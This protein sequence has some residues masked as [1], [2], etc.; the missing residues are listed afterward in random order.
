[1]ASLKRVAIEPGLRSRPEAVGE[2]EDAAA[3][4][5]LAGVGEV[6]WNADVGLF[7]SSFA[8]LRV[9][10]LVLVVV[11]LGAGERIGAAK[12]ILEPGQVPPAVCPLKPSEPTDG[13][14][15]SFVNQRRHVEVAVDRIVEMWPAVPVV[16]SDQVQRQFSSKF[17][18]G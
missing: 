10:V 7:G 1:M 16:Y 3:G 9:V 13:T 11:D 18:S 8:G 17:I 5:E 2:L 14:V 15:M 6:E 12:Q 4:E